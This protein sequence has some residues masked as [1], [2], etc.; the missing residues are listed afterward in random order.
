MKTL[1][2]YPKE[3]KISPDIQWELMNKA[4]LLGV[5]LNCIG[6]DRPISI[7]EH[8]IEHYDRYL[9]VINDFSLLDL[10]LVL[11]GG[12]R[13]TVLYCGDKEHLYEGAR[14]LKRVYAVSDFIVMKS[15]NIESVFSNLP[16]LS[17]GKRYSLV[18]PISAQ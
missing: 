1:I 10:T 3:F 6:Y 13:V 9:L 12:D 5:D 11:L 15:F 18:E 8:G 17:S 4:E 16:R 14:P 7:F 2:C